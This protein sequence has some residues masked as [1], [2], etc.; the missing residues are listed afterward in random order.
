MFF[1]IKDYIDRSRVLRETKRDRLWERRLARYKT[2]KAWRAKRLIRLTLDRHRCQQCQHRATDV[3]H[4]SYHHVGRER[5]RD[6]QS[7][8]DVCQL[9]ER[10]N[11]FWH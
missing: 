5:L 2:S 1:M 9:K 8:C 6:L 7:L 11:A 4:L 10:D 3:R